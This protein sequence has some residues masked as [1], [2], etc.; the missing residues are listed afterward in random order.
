[1]ENRVKRERNVLHR[2]IKT[3]L[4]GTIRGYQLL[5]SPLL[6]HTCRY[7]PSCSAYGME[8]IE[9]HGPMAGSWLT[10]KRVCRCHPWGGS[11]FDPVPEPIEKPTDHGSASLSS[12]G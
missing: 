12:R 7:L 5:V 8:A 3:L 10:A 6:G 9:R 1:M 2:A 11:G 4:K